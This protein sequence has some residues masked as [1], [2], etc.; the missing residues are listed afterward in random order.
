[1]K[2]AICRTSITLLILFGKLIKCIRLEITSG[3]LYFRL[4]YIIIMYIIIN[5]QSFTYSFLG[6][7]IIKNNLY[8]FY[9]VFITKL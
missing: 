4:G 5:I 9:K 7:L 6:I 3:L 2:G 1:M 8:Y